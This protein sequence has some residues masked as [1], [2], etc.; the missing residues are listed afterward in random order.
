MDVYGP[1]GRPVHARL[2]AIL[3][4]H[5]GPIPREML[6][7]IEWGFSRRMAS[8]RQSRAA[9]ASSSI[10]VFMHQPTMRPRNRTAGGD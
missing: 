7:P 9:S 4:V 3:F 6:A 5:G 8:W 10:I 1:V 2:P